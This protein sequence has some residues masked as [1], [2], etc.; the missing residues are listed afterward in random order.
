MEIKYITVDSNGQL[1]EVAK[2]IN[3]NTLEVI[4]TNTSAIKIIQAPEYDS[5][6]TYLD[7]VHETTNRREFIPA[8]SRNYEISTHREYNAKFLLWC[9]P[10]RRATGVTL[11][12]QRA[13]NGYQ[14]WMSE[15]YFFYCNSFYNTWNLRK[16]H[17]DIL[18][19]GSCYDPYL[20]KLKRLIES[21]KFDRFLEGRRCHTVQ[22]RSYKNVDAYKFVHDPHIKRC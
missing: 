7:R 21:E 17:I 18:N 11:H 20:K 22:L 8:N 1:F 13:S 16:C 2:K 10:S 6:I 12:R 5:K 19:Q 3:K 14:Y 15:K 9:S 4:P